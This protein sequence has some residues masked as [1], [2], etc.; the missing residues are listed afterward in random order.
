MSGISE[1]FNKNKNR[2]TV[3]VQPIRVELRNRINQLNIA[4]SQAQLMDHDHAKARE[5]IAR[6]DELVSLTHDFDSYSG[7]NSRMWLAFTD[8]EHWSEIYHALIAMDYEQRTPH[9]YNLFRV[10]D[11]GF[12]GTFTKEYREPALYHGIH[13]PGADYSP[14]FAERTRAKRIHDKYAQ[15]LGLS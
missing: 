3:K 8:T 12:R 2:T 4:A 6:S 11:W 15:V 7:F 13:V 5:L 10:L 9:V 1:Q 14:T